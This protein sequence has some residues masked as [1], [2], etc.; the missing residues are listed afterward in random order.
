LPVLSIIS[1]ALDEEESIQPLYEQIV[2]TLDPTGIPFEIILIDDGSCD[3]TYQIMRQIFKNDKR[4]KILH[5]NYSQ[6]KSAALAAGF[7]QSSGEVIVTLDADLQD[8]PHE[9][10]K[11]LL[12]LDEGFDLVSGWKKD[13]KDTWSKVAFSKVFNYFVS[14]SSHVPLHDI[15]CGLKCY[16]KDVVNQLHLYGKMHRFIPVMASWYGFRITE[17]P[18]THHPRRTGISKY[19]F[20][21]IYRGFFDFCTIWFLTHFRERPSHFFNSLGLVVFLLALCLMGIGS[22]FLFSSHLLYGFVF[23]MMSMGA[24][25]IGFNLFLIG[26]LAEFITHYFSRYEP[27]YYINETLE[28]DEPV[29]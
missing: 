20:R 17:V 15:N 29:L 2:E 1:P 6:G 23:Y 3:G 12:K 4:V 24:G 26:M 5:F 27:S 14:T 9:I 25:L 18:V 21:R 10:P 8:D 7:H 13:R 16:R 28:H 22:I 19:G 11:L